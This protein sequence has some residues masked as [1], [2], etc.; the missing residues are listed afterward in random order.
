MIIND[1]RIVR[2]FPSKTT[3]TPND[4]YC[5]FGYPP[6]KKVEADEVHISCLFTWD[7]PKAELMYKAWKQRGYLVKKGG[8]AYNAWGEDFIPGLY[9]KKGNVMASRG[10]NNN[11]WFC[12]VPKREGK[13]RE[14]PIVEGTNIIDSNILQ[15]SD[16]HVNNLFDMLEREKEKN[17]KASIKFTG[18]LEAKILKQWHVDRLFKLK[19]TTMYV[20]YDTPDDYE[21]L[22]RAS[23]M[24]F[25]SGFKSKHHSLWCYV[26]IGYPKDTIKNAKERLLQTLKLGVM[27][28]AMLYIGKN[29]KRS[30]YKDWK[31]LQREWNN[32][33]IVASKYNR[34]LKGLEIYQTPQS[35]YTHSLLDI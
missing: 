23:K 19:P 35:R 29:G 21:P 27:P 32:V 7:I 4:D 14:I 25:S 30:D 6:L 20:A 5:F 10:C 9:V 3:M 31:A 13:L 15:C 8:P 34:L 24:F 33:R 17:P 28:F 2:V 22:V 1:K 16:R 26:L 12:F 18:G 11:C